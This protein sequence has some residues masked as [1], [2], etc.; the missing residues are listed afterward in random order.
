VRTLLLCHIRC[1]SGPDLKQ[2]RQ[3]CADHA[4]VFP[5]IA[6]TYIVDAQHVPMWEQKLSS[7]SAVEIWTWLDWKVPDV[8]PNTSASKA[9][10]RRSLAVVIAKRE[11]RLALL[12]L[13]EH[14]LDRLAGD[15]G[16]PREFK[17]QAMVDNFQAFFDAFNARDVANDSE[18][19]MVTSRAREIVDSFADDPAALRVNDTQRKAVVEKLQRIQKQLN[20]MT[21]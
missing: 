20:Q 1:Y 8:L 21:R 9:V 12:R 2:L 3:W 11:H 5:D 4:G 16:K 13:V 7:S 15:G 14:A 17:A 6:G 18:L 10:S 19:G